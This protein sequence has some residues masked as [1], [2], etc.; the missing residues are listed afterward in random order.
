MKALIVTIGDEI[1]IGQIIDT[2]S[3]FISKELLKIGIEVS[4]II[5]IGDNKKQIVNNLRSA[6][7]NYDI[8]I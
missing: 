1:L 2:N 7:N 8:V 4:K 5:S 6:Q 3:T